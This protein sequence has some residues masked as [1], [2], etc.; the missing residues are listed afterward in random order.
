MCE[1]GRERRPGQLHD[2]FLLGLAQLRRVRRGGVVAPRL[3]APGE[4]DAGV[5]DHLGPVAAHLGGGGHVGHCPGTVEGVGEELQQHRDRPGAAHR[6]AAGVDLLREPEGVDGCRAAGGRA[7]ERQQDRSESA[8]GGERRVV[9]GG[10]MMCEVRGGHHDGARAEEVGEPSR[11][12]DR[13]GV[14]GRVSDDDRHD[15]DRPDR[16]QQER[17]LDLETVLANVRA[18]RPSEL[19][20]RGEPGDRVAV[21]RN[22]PQRCGEG[23]DVGSGSAPPEN[24]AWCEGPRRMTRVGFEP[25]SGANAFPAVAPEKTPPAWGAITATGARPVPFPRRGTR[26][27]R[28]R[29]GGRRQGRTLPPPRAGGPRREQCS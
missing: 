10:P 27:H 3:P 21:H 9:V 8:I 15:R 20:Q 5:R 4:V 7:G 16:G 1:V 18:R 23:G 28:S 19:G 29:A 17:E 26:E 2:R 14:V 13:Q 6:V 25:A 24:P 12:G 11:H 22:L